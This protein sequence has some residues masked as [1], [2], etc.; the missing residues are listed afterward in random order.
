M[1]KSNA[2]ETSGI[3]VKIDAA[4]GGTPAGSAS[5]VG[6]LEDAGS[7]VGKS[8]SVKKYTPINDTQ[9]EEIVALGSLSQKPFNMTVL[10]DPEGAE[11]INKIETAIDDNEPIEISIELN[12]S[13]GA[14]GTIIKQIAKVSDFEVKGER[15][16]M[17]I[18]TF[19]AERVGDATVTPASAT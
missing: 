5:D 14:N 7:L 15:D 6:H 18:A 19:T 13:L 11:G 10:Y 8:R 3:V 4:P 9:Y 17:T 1:A 12:N 16:G 2:P